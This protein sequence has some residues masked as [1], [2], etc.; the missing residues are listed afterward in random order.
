MSEFENFKEEFPSKEKI[1][2]SFTG[3]KKIV[4]KS[5]LLRFAINLKKKKVERLSQ[6]VLKM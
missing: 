6:L 5:M 4:I 3:K 2:S 1:Y